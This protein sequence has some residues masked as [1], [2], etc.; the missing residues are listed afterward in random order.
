MFSSYFQ[1]IAKYPTFRFILE[2]TALAFVSRFF[3][4]LPVAIILSVIGIDL[5]ASNIESLNLSKN[6]VSEIFYA[7]IL[8][9][10]IETLLF[11]WLPLK[12]L[13]FLRI[14]L[15]LAIISTTLLFA[16]FHLDDGLINFIGMLPIGF[17]FV[18]AFV[19]RQ[20]Y[21]TRQAIFAVFMIH[22]LTNLLAT[23]IYLMSN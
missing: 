2:V 17:L 9:P 13:R 14:P 11:Q 20:K 16:Y 10:F 5:G 21:S 15:Y 7:V 23:V 1:R 6:F 12:I 8:A 19:V 3:I 22:A 4:V 18:W